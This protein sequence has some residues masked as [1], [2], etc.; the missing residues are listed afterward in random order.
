V[1]WEPRLCI[2][3]A[4]CLNG[5]PQVFNSRRRPWVKVDAAEAEQIAR[6]VLTCPTGALRFERLDGGE[7]EAPPEP[8]VIEA[9]PNGPLY[10][11]GRLRVVDQSGA[12]RLMTRCAL[13]RCGKS[14]NKPYCDGSHKMAGFKT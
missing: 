13:C 5:L 9:Q 8:A 14:W 4:N 1:Y 11:R 10:L 7:Q 2:H 3:T 6:V 12:S